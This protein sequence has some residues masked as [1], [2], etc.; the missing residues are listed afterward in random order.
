MNPNFRILTFATMTILFSLGPL[1]A[2]KG[3][4]SFVLEEFSNLTDRIDLLKDEAVPTGRLESLLEKGGEKEKD[5]EIFKKALPIA[6][7]LGK[8]TDPLSKQK[9]YSELVTLFQQVIG[10]HDRSG[11]VLYHCPKTG[12]QWITNSETVKNPFDRK[13]ISCIQKK[14]E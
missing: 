12:K 7:E 9:F 6:K 13:N 10:Y 14:E 4:A 1:S 11:A 8:T 2:H 5:S 3:R